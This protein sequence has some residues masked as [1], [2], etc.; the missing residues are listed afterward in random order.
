MSELADLGQ[1]AHSPPPG[2]RRSVPGYPA[3][4][5]GAGLLNVFGVFAIALG[6][7]VMILGGLIGALAYRAPQDHPIPGASS[8][9]AALI[10]V[11]SMCSSGVMLVIAGVFL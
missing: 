10:P 11:V 7:G 9:T 2:P 1:G 3:I 6:I 4:V 8:V 5:S